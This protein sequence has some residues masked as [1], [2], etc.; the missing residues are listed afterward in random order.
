MSIRF[1]ENE[2]ALLFPAHICAANSGTILSIGPSLH[3]LDLD[4]IINNHMLE[5]F[6]IERPIH[7]NSYEALF[8]YEGT[9]ILKTKKAAILSHESHRAR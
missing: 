3:R 4:G 2:L 6:D 1:N 7:I 9:I 8:A 5:V